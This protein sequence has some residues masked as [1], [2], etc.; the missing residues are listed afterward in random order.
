MACPTTR[1]LRQSHTRVSGAST[2]AHVLA[3]MRTGHSRLKSFLERR[4]LEDDQCECGEDVE[5]LRHFLLHYKRYD[6]QR[7]RIAVELGRN[8]SNVSHML[9]G[10][11]LYQRLDGT[12]PDRPRE[13]W[14][15]NMEV[16]RTVI[17]LAL[18]T[19]RLGPRAWWG[20]DDNWRTNETVA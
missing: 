14:K 7:Y 18:E 2:E 13:A 3:Q 4:G 15:P 17:R 10:R 8:Y 11:G 20:E 12:N 19:G 16:V 5:T 1:F 6:S 9:G